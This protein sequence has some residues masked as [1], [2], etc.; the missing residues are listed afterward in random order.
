[1]L[2]FVVGVGKSRGFGIPATSFFI[3]VFSVFESKR[4]I[5][6]LNVETGMRSFQVSLMVPVSG[7]DFD[8]GP[9]LLLLSPSLPLIA[10]LF[11]RALFQSSNLTT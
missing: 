11:I 8:F 6:K 3:P 4:G 2:R 7:S 10:F 9:R 1:M 5:G